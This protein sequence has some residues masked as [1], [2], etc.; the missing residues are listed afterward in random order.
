MT[1]IKNI[2]LIYPSFER[3]GVE[4]IIKNLIYYFTKKK[5]FVY[6]IS[7]VENKKIFKYRKGYFNLIKLKKNDVVIRI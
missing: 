4:N 1:N 7:N 5:Y 2:I 6:L 3:G